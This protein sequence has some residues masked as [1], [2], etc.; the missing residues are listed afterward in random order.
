MK[1]TEL[2]MREWAES[3]G[4]P[5]PLY[6]KSPYDL[7]TAGDNEQY[8]QISWMLQNAGFRIEDDEAVEFT[9]R[10]LKIAFIVHLMDSFSYSEID[11]LAEKLAAYVT[12]CKAAD[13]V[14]GLGLALST[15]DVNAEEPHK[16]PHKHK[17]PHKH[18]EPCDYCDEDEDEPF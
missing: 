1:Y 11:A 7:L 17:H 16:K 5:Y 15:A 14:G 10:M 13:T 6:G 2:L 9:P 3:V 8:E 12:A 4:S 18:H